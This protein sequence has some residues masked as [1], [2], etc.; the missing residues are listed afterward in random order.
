MSQSAHRVLEYLLTKAAVSGKLSSTKIRIP[1]AELA[2]SIG[3]VESKPIDLIVDIKLEWVENDGDT[4]S[5]VEMEGS[6]DDVI[7]D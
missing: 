1:Y 3:S 2:T 7:E 6:A 4:E 5:A